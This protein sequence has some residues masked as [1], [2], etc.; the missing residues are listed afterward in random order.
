M[1]IQFSLANT[2]SDYRK[3]LSSL[4]LGLRQ[5]GFMFAATSLASALNYLVHFA[6]SR[7][8]GPVEYGVFASLT[9][10]Y[11]L[12]S[13]P[14]VIF[15]LVTAYYLA[16]FHA[17][18]EDYRS[19][20]LLIDITKWASF[21]GVI[22]GTVI[23]LGSPF[24]ATFLQI[25][26]PTP[27][28]VVAGVVF[29]GALMTIATGALQGLQK[30]FALGTNGIIGSALRLAFTIGLIAL[31]LGASG[32]LAAQIIAGL[33]TFVIAV[34]LLSPLLRRPSSM[35][36]SDHGLTV[37]EVFAYAGWVMIGTSCLA[38]LTN[39]DVMIV[40]H[41]FPP[42]VAGQYAAASVL[43]KI[44]LFF[45]G[46]ITAVLFPKAVERVTL[47]QDPSRIARQAAAAVGGLCGVLVIGYFLVPGFLV[48]L[49]FGPGYTVAIP[50]IGP[51]G[52]TMA[53]YALVTLQMTYYL[54]IHRTR[55]I[56]LLVV[57]TISLGTAL[58]LF[59]NSLLEVII[60]QLINAAA[61]LVVGELIFRGILI[62]IPQLKIIKKTGDS[63]DI[64]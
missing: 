53:L 28:L 61:L 42:A 14:L 11:T 38:A 50:L 43:A 41:Y 63:Q 16:Q 58:I 64:T 57:S 5:A 6:S 56:A 47:Q 13:T 35:L 46:A 52:A 32:A 55:Y 8:L 29:V 45:P 54:A 24:L 17:R 4:P 51:F 60:I 36:R 30:F 22:L 49:L 9:S 44:I 62:D 21:I 20:S 3:K 34:A 1:D 25:P 10:F 23:A 7:M 18:G 19:R 26:S 39:M 12:I 31:G 59:H 37:R 2:I 27:I 33:V 40:K 15:T 48:R